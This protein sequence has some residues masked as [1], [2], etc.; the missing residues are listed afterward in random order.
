MIYQSNLVVCSGEISLRSDDQPFAFNQS[1]MRGSSKSE[2]SINAYRWTFEAD[3]VRS[4]FG[5]PATHKRIKNQGVTVWINNAKGCAQK[6][7]FNENLIV[8]IGQMES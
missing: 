5:I 2:N 6:V 7:Y 1:S 8:L 3:H 4:F